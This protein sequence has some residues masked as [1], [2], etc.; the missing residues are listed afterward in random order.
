MKVIK[1]QYTKQINT[2]QNVWTYRKTTDVG[3]SR[4]TFFTGSVAAQNITNLGYRPKKKIQ[5]E[6]NC[7]TV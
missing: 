6:E 3:G 7:H 2:A 1:T 4:E 5:I